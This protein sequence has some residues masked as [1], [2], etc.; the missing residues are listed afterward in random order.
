MGKHYEL[1][2]WKGTPTYNAWQNMKRRCD[3]RNRPNFND[4]GGRGITVCERWLHS[5]SNFLDDMGEKPENLTLDRIDNDK[6]YF[7]ENCRWA[8]VSQQNFNQRVRKDN[9]QGV[10]GVSFSKR[11]GK[12]KAYINRK[13]V[14]IFLGTFENIELAKRARLVAEGSL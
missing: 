4:Y 13:G 1:H 2:G 3:D 8:T 6:G 5:F 11:E 10:K 12:F 14:Q 9:T 7:P